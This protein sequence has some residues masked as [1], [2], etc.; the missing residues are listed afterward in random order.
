VNTLTEV[1]VELFADY[2]QFYIQDEKAVGDL[3]EKWTEEAVNMLLAIKI[4]LN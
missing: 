3:S 1:R 2:L 4:N